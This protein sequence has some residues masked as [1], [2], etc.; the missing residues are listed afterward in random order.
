VDLWV[1]D[2]NKSFI[3]ISVKRGFMKLARFVL[4]VMVMSLTTGC[5]K[6]PGVYHKLE[7]G[8]AALNTDEWEY[9]D[10]DF[11]LDTANN[12]FDAALIAKRPNAPEEILQARHN[13][14]DQAS[15]DLIADMIIF[16]GNVQNHFWHKTNPKT[17]K[18]DRQQALDD[19]VSK[20]NI[21]LAP[22]RGEICGECAVE[23]SCV[24]KIEVDLESA[25]IGVRSG[26]GMQTVFL[27]RKHSV[28]QTSS[29]RSPLKI[30]CTPCLDSKCEMDPVVSDAGGE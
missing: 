23:G 26:Q 25:D 2:L 6:I 24:P 14:T 12:S 17:Y 29:S 9:F 30:S 7:C 5:D 16:A 4:T 15:K 20:L 10:L 3:T 8:G 27:K 28:P 1:T 19:L 21:Y 11:K 13:I 22:Y 18:Q